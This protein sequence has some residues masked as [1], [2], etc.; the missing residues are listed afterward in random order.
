MWQPCSPCCSGARPAKPQADNECHTIVT[1]CTFME[2]G[3]RTSLARTLAAFDETSSIN[4]T[5]KEK[6]VKHLWNLGREPLLIYYQKI[7][8]GCFQVKC[9]EL[10]CGKYR[11]PNVTTASVNDALQLH[12]SMIAPTFL[13]RISHMLWSIYEQFLPKLRDLRFSNWVSICYS[14]L[15]FLS[16]MLF[17]IPYITE[18][19][20]Y[21]RLLSRQLLLEK[22]QLWSS[23]GNTEISS[24]Q[25]CYKYVCSHIFL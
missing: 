1:T 16:V 2:R 10:N 23:N 11:F 19:T 14:W 5:I 7:K 15:S 17:C 22:E 3:G 24:K 21:T 12:L 25:T 13:I 8:K 4:Q 9:L 18:I 6:A 20:L